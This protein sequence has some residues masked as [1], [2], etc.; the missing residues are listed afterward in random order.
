MHVSSSSE[1]FALK[2]LE[3]GLR[4]AIM[5]GFVEVPMLPEIANR[6]LSL[7]QDPEASAAQ[8]ADLIQGDQSLAGHVMRIANSVA[9][10]PM[11]N[12]TSLQ[13]AVARLGMNVMCE[14][15]LAAVLGAKLFH[16]PGYE[17]YV[18]FNWQHALA[19]SLW[20]KEIA[21][22]ANLDQETAFL[23]GLLHSIGRPA[24]L[25]TL[26]ELAGQKGISVTP[27][28]VHR[29]ENKYSQPVS[30]LVV[31]RWKMP[32]AIINA[33]KPYQALDKAEPAYDVAAA[34]H[35]AARFA[36]YML[37]IGAEDDEETLM[38]LDALDVL[39]LNEEQVQQLLALQDSVQLRVEQLS[40]Q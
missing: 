14:I 8:M 18:E 1:F 9:Y 30:D 33:I 27:E 37:D 31:M 39:K 26:L 24:V 6:A 10:T 3:E 16:T 25:Q 20:S 36:T 23:A 11:A 28:L 32:A 34:V 13:Q 2:T 5:E 15:A 12:L 38:E 17:D 19:T 21:R 22:Q 35:V 29:L 40:R 7:T 4:E